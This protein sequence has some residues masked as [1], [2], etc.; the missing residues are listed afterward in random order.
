MAHFDW[1]TKLL[2]LFVVFIVSMGYYANIVTIEQNLG[3]KNVFQLQKGDAT[4]GSQDV[5]ANVSFANGGENLSWNNVQLSV[6]VEA[7]EFSCM[8]GGMSSVEQSNGT[9]RSTLNADGKTFTVNIDTNIE[10]DVQEFDLFT[11]RAVNGSSVSLTVKQTDIFLGGNVTAIAVEDAFGDVEYDETLAFNESSEQRLEWYTYDFV[12]HQIIPDSEVYIIED[13]GEFFKLQFMS[14]Y[15][16]EGYA[17][18]VTIL[19]AP[20]ENASI[21]AL[22]DDTMVQISPCSILENGDGVWGAN[23]TISLRENNVNFCSERCSIRVIALFEQQI[24]AGKNTLH[25]NDE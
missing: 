3:T 1:R 14:Y 21:P 11:M 18:H 12:G 10:D 9:I 5:L 4:D 22:V 17:R 25:F 13:R 20:L 19:V 6:E 15:D 2:S 24:I 8:V 7:Q 23:E 16:S